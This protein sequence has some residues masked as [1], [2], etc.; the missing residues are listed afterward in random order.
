MKTVLW[1]FLLIVSISSFSQVVDKV[2]LEYYEEKLSSPQYGMSVSHDGKLGAFLFESGKLNIFDLQHSRQVKSINLEFEEIGE[3]RFS[4]DDSQ[5]IVIERNRIRVLD[6]NTGEV[7]MDEKW[8]EEIIC[9]DIS[10]DNKL[11]VGSVDNINIWDLSTFKL[12]RTI[13][14]RQNIATVFF[15]P[16]GKQMLI[17]PRVNM[18]GSKTFIY[19]YETGELVRTLDKG[20][21]GTYNPAGD[22]IFIH[23]F[24][25]VKIKR[26]SAII[27]VLYDLSLSD[28]NDSHVIYSDLEKSSDVGTIMSSLQVGEKLVG[29]AGYRGFTVYDIP[30]G[31]KVFTTKKTKRERSASAIGFYKNYTAKA[32]YKLNDDK[33]L[34][35]AYG[36]NINQIYSASQ[37]EIVGYLFADSDG[38]FATITR[39]GKFDGSAQAS[40]K[41]YWSA[42]NSSR[43]TSVASTFSRGF[44]PNLLASLLDSKTVIEEFD[45]DTEIASIPE[46]KI[47]SFNQ[48]KVSGQNAELTTSQKAGNLS[49]EITT[50]IAQVSQVR[51][52]QNNKLVAIAE[53]PKQAELSFDVSLSNSFGEANYFYVTATGKGGIDSEKQTMTINYTGKTDAKPRL[54]LVT[55]GVNEYR[56]P[57]Y[58]LNYALADADAF[59]TTLAQGAAGVFDD[60]KKIT[61]RNSQFTK[62]GIINAL[63]S[64][65]DESNEQDMMIF[66]YAG[67]GVMSQTGQ[68]DFFIVPHDVTQLYGRDDMLAEKALSATELKEISRK[69]NA[70]KQ[71]FIL[72]ACQ[73][74]AALDAVTRRGVAEE[75]AIAQLARSTGTFWITATGSEQFA[76]EFESLGHGVF[77]YALIEGLQGKADGGNPDNKITVRELNAYIESR[78]PELAEEYKGTPQFPSGYS[79]GNDFPLVI[80]K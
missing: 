6:W 43:K 16:A 56:N 14:I 44:T 55:V 80:Y 15:S 39:D 23:R 27:P 64:V 59:E 63:K 38:D 32:I 65:Q 48:D 22:K 29:T 78:V 4:N 66:Y 58:N 25:K 57:K 12:L 10:V 21:L 17:N 26:S 60:V 75:R 77:T 19:N 67:H 20:F 46:I 72:D 37:N 36:D 33:V 79:F 35:N 49:V 3:I 18:L 34:I 31:G 2:R 40:D 54:Y 24:R 7:K 61:L 51:V 69:I 50:D 47:K 1:V 74:A 11:A 8:D 68:S 41:L 62:A 53:N 70:Q 45:I 9:G 73:S 76:T 42:R 13:P 71:V 5:I 30:N 52:F 28:D